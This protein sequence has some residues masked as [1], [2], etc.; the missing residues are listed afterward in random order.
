MSIENVSDKGQALVANS[1]LIRLNFNVLGNTKKSLVEV[2]TDGDQNRYKT[3]KVLLDSP[4][5]K[6]ISS[7]DLKLRLWMYKEC[8]PFDMGV[9][10]VSIKKVANVVGVLKE[11]Q[12]VKRPALVAAFK[13]AYPQL[14]K[15]ALAALKSDFNMGDFLPVE[16]LDSRFSFEFNILGFNV[17]EELAS[18]NGEIFQAEVEKA[19]MHINSITHEIE[20]AQRAVLLSMIDTLDDKLAEGKIPNQKSIEK[21]QK[22]LAEFELQDV[23][24]DKKLAPIVA[25]LHALTQGVSSKGIKD[26]VTFQATLA[27]KILTVTSSLES[28]VEIRPARRIKKDQDDE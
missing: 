4:E 26:N 3:H 12:K 13:A 27:E 11:Y 22:F 2:V 1:V 10:L 8:V 23:T 28:M 14:V 7:E 5:L 24:N 20:Q 15:E 17:P 21:L 9:M 19:Q 25:E 18:I 16:Q 6:K